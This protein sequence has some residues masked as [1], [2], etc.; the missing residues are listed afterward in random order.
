MAIF[1]MAIQVF[2]VMSSYQSIAQ[3]FKKTGNPRVSQ[4]KSN[5]PTP[6]QNLSHEVMC[7][8]YNGITIVCFCAKCQGIGSDNT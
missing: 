3:K 1:N 4:K 7:I 2:V 8:L 5:P 6:T